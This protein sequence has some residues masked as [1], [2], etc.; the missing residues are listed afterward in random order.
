MDAQVQPGIR[1]AGRAATPPTSP[2]SVPSPSKQ[3]GGPATLVPSSPSPA[4]ARTAP[5]PVQQRRREGPTV[6]PL[7]GSLGSNESCQILRPP[8]LAGGPSWT[9][10]RPNRLQPPVSWGR[11]FPLPYGT[12]QAP[13]GLTRGALASQ[14]PG[15]QPNH[16]GA[17]RL[18]QPTLPQTHQHNTTVAKKR[19]LT[20]LTN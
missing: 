2:L 12:P 14:A 7:S 15:E 17:F 20:N 13:A 3:S 19:M 16:S 9:N 8:G 18:F 11:P 4:K 6:P 10:P 1:G 5:H